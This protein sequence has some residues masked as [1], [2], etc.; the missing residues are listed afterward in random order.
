[1][2]E[3]ALHAEPELKKVC[4]QQARQDEEKQNEI[5][6]HSIVIDETYHYKLNAKYLSFTSVLSVQNN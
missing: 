5:F 1:M 6:F 2:R 3:D 4:E